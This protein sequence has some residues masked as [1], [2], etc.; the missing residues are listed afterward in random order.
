M[1]SVDLGASVNDVVV[2]TST[3]PWQRDGV[4]F[5]RAGTISLAEPSWPY[6]DDATATTVDLHEVPMIS[7]HEWANRGPSTMRV[8]LPELGSTDSA[9]VRSTSSQ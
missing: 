4:T 6:G 3:A 5:V 8:W 2:D 7:Y 9:P 1:E